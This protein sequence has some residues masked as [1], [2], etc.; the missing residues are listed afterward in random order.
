MLLMPA[1]KTLGS[2]PGTGACAKDGYGEGE[3]EKGLD[4]AMAITKLL[5]RIWLWRKQSSAAETYFQNTR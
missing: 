4:M 2:I 1:A 5:H 3:E